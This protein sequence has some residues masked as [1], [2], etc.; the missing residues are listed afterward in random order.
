MTDSANAWCSDGPTAVVVLVTCFRCGE[1]VDLWATAPAQR[2]C[3]K[4][5]YRCDPRC[6]AAVTKKK[7]KRRRGF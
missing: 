2:P 6:G 5:G 1:R 7:R 3:G 4:W